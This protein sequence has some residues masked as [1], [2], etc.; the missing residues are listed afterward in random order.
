MAKQVGAAQHPKGSTWCKYGDM[1]GKSA[2]KQRGANT[3][4]VDTSLLN[5]DEEAQIEVATRRSLEAGNL[6]DATFEK[7]M[8]MA[9][10]ASLQP[11]IPRRPFVARPPPPTPAVAVAGAGTAAD[12]TPECDVEVRDECLL[13]IVSGDTER[14][15]VLQDIYEGLSRETKDKQMARAN[16]LLH[17][18]DKSVEERI[19]G[20]EKIA[21]SRRNRK[22]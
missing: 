12:P 1:R 7:Q 17:K 10:A 6:L 3:R 15:D 14:G 13:E 5:G 19:N 16:A 20:L 18:K 21:E 4:L 8:E 2:A 9:T 22:K 11:T